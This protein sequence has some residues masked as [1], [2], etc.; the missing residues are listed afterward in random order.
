MDSSLIYD[1]QFVKSDCH[2][3]LP[4]GQYL[5]FVWFLTVA[6]VLVSVEAMDYW[7]P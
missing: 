5:L 3:H 6:M 4:F 2:G 1:G 7:N